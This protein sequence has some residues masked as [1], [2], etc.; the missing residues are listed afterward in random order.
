MKKHQFKLFTGILFL[1]SFLSINAQTSVSGTIVDKKNGKPLPYATIYFEG[2]RI[3]T[4]SDADGNFRLFSPQAETIIYGSFLG[5]KTDGFKIKPNENNT[6]T[7]RIGEESK[8]SKLK[9]EVRSTR[10]LAKDTLAV[11]IMRNVIRNKDNN[12]P[13]A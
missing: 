10:K 1:V 3:G 13:S 8:R 11:R 4:K 5:F 6:I 2:K 12:K 9:A 7:I